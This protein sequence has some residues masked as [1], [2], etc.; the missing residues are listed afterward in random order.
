MEN[1]KNQKG[2]CIHDGHRKRLTETVNRVGLDGLSNI[3]VLEYIL[4]FI[5]PRGDVN[6]LAHRLL[7]RFQN[8]QTVLEASVE[9]LMEVKGVGEMTA[10]KIHSLLEVFYYY[11]SEKLKYQPLKSVGDFLDYIEQLL[12]YRAEEELYIFGVNS[13]GYIIQGRRLAKGRTSSVSIEMRDVALYV[14][15]TKVHGVYLVHN[16][17]DGSS[18]PSKQDLVSFENMQG[19]FNFSGCKLIDSMV[20]GNDGIYSMAR[21]NTVR[22]FSRGVEYFQSLLL[23]NPPQE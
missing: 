8:V 18:T 1:D 6:P 17:P 13:S 23:D 14:S 16:H 3:Q 5:F 15:T 9:D 22:I 4:F 7:D 2:K 10:Q 19:V 20:V 11:T 12:R 21:K